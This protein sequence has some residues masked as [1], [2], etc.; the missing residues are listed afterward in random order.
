MTSSPLPLR[1]LLA[2]FLSAGLFLSG[3]ES[4]MDAANAPDVTPETRAASAVLPQDAR[5]TLMVNLKSL[6]ENGPEKMRDALSLSSFD[7]ASEKSARVQDFLASTG[8][9]PDEDLERMYLAMSDVGG[10]EAPHFV[11]YGTF[12]RD[13]LQNALRSTYGSDLGETSQNGITVFTAQPGA[14]D[15]AMSFAVI[16]EDMIVGASSADRVVSMIE[17]RGDEVESKGSENDALLRAASQGRSAWFVTRNLN[18]PDLEE[19]ARDT[20]AAE[21]LGMLSRAVRDLAGSFSF[22]SDGTMDGTLWLVPKDEAA[23][24]DV[25]DVAR[26]LLA[27]AKQQADDPDWSTVLDEMTVETSGSRVVVAFTAPTRLFDDQ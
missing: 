23:S 1:Y 24:G 13:R 14:S 18:V 21:D 16:N 10:R 9:D 4:G 25:A 12:D 19:G 15:E 20:E 26:G 6:R 11:V 17:R 2:A 8:I 3:C 22:E 5:F 7:G 27:T